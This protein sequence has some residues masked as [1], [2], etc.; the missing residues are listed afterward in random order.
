MSFFQNAIIYL[1]APKK[2]P[3]RN[4]HIK[5]NN[6]LISHAQHDKTKLI[7]LTQHFF[8][9]DL[10]C[11]RSAKHIAPRDNFASFLRDLSADMLRAFLFLY[12][13]E[14]MAAGVP[15]ANKFH[16]FTAG[17]LHKTTFHIT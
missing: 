3:A 12:K 2:T 13:L 16:I 17:I 14:S 8:Q 15:P 5:I 6:T 11:T 7:F 4:F 10:K 1:T 9:S